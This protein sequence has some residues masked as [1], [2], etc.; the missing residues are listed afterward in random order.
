[1]CGPALNR[2]LQEEPKTPSSM[3]RATILRERGRLEEA[4]KEFLKSIELTPET[5]SSWGSG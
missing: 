1:M 3:L 5:R 2:A 4:R